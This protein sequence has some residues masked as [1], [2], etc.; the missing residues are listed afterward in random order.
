MDWYS[1]ATIAE[2]AG[3]GMTTPWMHQ[4]AETWLRNERRLEPGAMMECAVQSGQ[5]DFECC[6]LLPN[7]T[8]PADWLLFPN[9]RGGK[10]VGIK[11]RNI[12]EKI[13]FQKKGS[14]R[15]LYTAN[16]EVLDRVGES[17]EPLI[18]VEGELDWHA[19]KQAGF[20][21]VGSAPSANLG[22]KLEPGEDIPCPD[23]IAKEYDQI[24]Q[25]RRVIIATDSDAAGSHLKNQ[26]IRHLDRF[27]IYEVEFPT[28]CKDM[29]D[30]LK[31][32]GKDNI[33]EGL[34]VIRSLI[35]HAKPVQVSGVRKLSEVIRDA[36]AQFETTGWYDLD[37]MVRLTPGLFVLTGYSGSGKSQFLRQLVSNLTHVKR[38]SGIAGF[39]E[40][41][42]REVAEEIVEMITRINE[43]GIPAMRT[44]EAE[45]LV[46][47][48]LTFLD[49]R[50][51]RGGGER[52]TTDWLVDLGEA[53]VL[54]DNIRYMIVDT[55]S[56][57][58]R[59]TSSHRSETEQINEELQKLQD[60]GHQ[61]GVVVILCAH[62]TK[63]KGDISH[64]PTE[65]DIAGSRSFNDN[66]DGVWV[67]HK[68]SKD[69]DASYF[70]NAKV[71]N[72]RKG[73]K[74]GWMEMLFNTETRMFTGV[75]M[76]RPPLWKDFQTGERA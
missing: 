8:H 39:F 42:N 72:Q 62:P 10:V 40:D 60:F 3:A 28:G 76:E 75:P 70:R 35:K 18:I 53:M 33:E 16:T 21:M 32:Y 34:S 13:L 9:Y 64:P 29:N 61:F 44:G 52:I 31:V 45:D 11:M 74:L 12:D 15:L 36:P 59:S 63:P 23:W 48:K 6:K 4:D 41:D 56:R 58:A 50:Q 66:A 1:F 73:G 46:E 22:K 19:V 38:W 2:M 49:M 20:E 47:D 51:A 14:Q 55:W 7:N 24:I 43:P 25:A 54:K 5:A 27:R 65:Y 67:F 57:V 30:V 68:P 17:N 37:R 71:R 69:S 26:M